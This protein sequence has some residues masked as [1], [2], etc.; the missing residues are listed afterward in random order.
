MSFDSKGVWVPKTQEE[1]DRFVANIEEATAAEASPQAQAYIDALAARILET[2]RATVKGN[3]NFACSVSNLLET[4]VTPVDIVIP[5][6]GGLHVLN[7][8]V[9]S[10]QQRTAWPHR[11]I[12]VD[13][14][15]PDERTKAWLGMWQE[16]NPQHTVLFNQKN[17]GFAAT[18]NRGIE[19][20]ENPYI[21]VL[22][23]DTVVTPGWLVKMV[24]ALK[25]DERNKIVNPCT[26]NT[27]VI[28]VP[29]QEGYDFNDMNRAIEKMSPHL[30]P[31]IMPTGFCFMFERSITAE[32]G[33]F[34]EGYVS[35]GEETD[36]WMRCITRIVNGQV[37]NW[38][39]VL[40]DDTYIWHE[41][42]TSF[43]VLGDEEHMGYR[44]SGA[45]RFHAA[46]PAFKEWQR[47]FDTEKT[48][49]TLRAPIAETIISK[50]TPRYKV[51]FIVYSTE[52]CGGMKVI[53]D[54]VNLLNETNVEAKVVRIKRTTD[55]ED[56]LLPSLRSA[57]VVFTEGVQD[58]LSNFGDRV[59]KD[60]IV[61]AGTGELMPA[62]AELTRKNDNLT[63]VHFSQSDDVSIAPTKEI[64]KAIREANK[65]A[66]FTIT[67]SKWTAKK[68]AKSH[69]VHG[70]VS[71]GYDDYMFYPRGRQHGDERK[72]L[73]ITLG[74]QGYPFKGH[75]RG[76]DMCCHLMR[77]AKDNKKELRILAA[78]VSSV[79]GFPFIV[80][81]GRL[82]QTKFA[83]LLGREVDVFCDPASNHSYGL[84][85]LEA[86]ASGA[87]PVCW[88]NKG[89]LEYATNDIDAIVL[90]NKTTSEVVA[91]R[92]YNI[93]FNEPK[94]FA[95]LREAAQLTSRKYHRSE[96]LVDCVKFF[97][98][99]LG[100]MPDCKKIAVITPH[101]RKYGGPT[102][103]LDIAHTLQELG[104]DVTLYTIYP[105]INPSIQNQCKV[106]IRV[107]W[108][109]IPPCD[110]LITNSD[111]EYNKEFT[112]MAHVKKKVMLKLSHNQRFQSHETDSLN[113]KWDAIVTSTNW[114][115]KACEKVTEGWEY[116]THKNARRV[117]W[118]HYAHDMFHRPFDQRTFGNLE[119][120]T[121][122]VGTLI[123]AHPL[124]GTNEALQAM[125]ALAQKFPGKLSFVGVGEVP[126]FGKA[127]P[128]WLNYFQSPT[129]EEMAQVMAQTDIW[130]NASHTE[131]L[132]R[133]TLEAMSA[134][135]AIIAT[136]TG[137][138]F[139]KDGDNCALV[140]VGSVNDLTKQAERL[141]L[142]SQLRR[143]LVARGYD[144]AI[145]AADPTQY[146]K[147]WKKLIG[148]L[149]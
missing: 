144:T 119:N 6:Y 123:H 66:E 2:S 25:A 3:K 34:D 126:T 124:K 45:A 127:K 125:T 9:A 83:D 112:E 55:S 137:A 147:N 85:T 15:S 132:G 73:L 136:D 95:A 60:G 145:A 78:G 111:N 148:D 46:W 107:D 96:C 103:I 76:V 14:C 24:L 16:E 134:G 29:L 51:A 5:V 131:G 61:V 32:I 19:E 98:K 21:C 62:V 69:K 138:E 101:L 71:V 109:D 13:D 31:E 93:L 92:I 4:G 30:Y 27:A 100:L 12:L 37:S 10:V 23:S 97:E 99:T 17:R 88:N 36:Y 139:L 117:G 108:R 86:M 63:S 1:V 102:T 104:H 67:N 114:L 135:C 115:K 50:E 90:S 142:K 48:L 18:V 44:K 80:G 41:R 47:N 40:A 84:P 42:G 120:K 87:V 146:K 141:I 122:V 54:I 39:A 94:R 43:S 77:L 72:T 116:I 56:P 33:L 52:N 58:F 57:P 20:G 106:P 79:P 65:E 35:Y 59:F 26:N 133:M 113:L 143:D 105:D 121:I 64:S 149:F 110:L 128:P 49:R 129:R 22:N 7:E 38:R 28:N 70:S 91:E 8:C 130:L 81:L 140:P 11:I 82:A 118:Y 53:A 68:M 89:I 74:N 75:D